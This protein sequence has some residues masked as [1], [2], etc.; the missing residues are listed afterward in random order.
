V[1]TLVVSLGSLPVTPGSISG[2]PV[3][4]SGSSNTYEIAAVGGATSYAWTLPVGWLGSSTTDTIHTLAGTAGGTISVTASNGCG[5]SSAQILNV[6]VNLSPTP[7]ISL[8]TNNICF[9]NAEGIIKATGNP[10][11]GT[12]SGTGVSPS[13][14][15][16]PAAAGV[17]VHTITYV[18]TDGNGCSGTATDQVTVS[19]CVSTT[20]L[21][22]QTSN[23]FVYPNPT[24]GLVTL[25]ISTPLNAGFVE[26]CGQC[27]LIIYSVLGDVILQ[28]AINNPTTTLDLSEATPGIYFLQIKN[29]NSSIIKKIIK[30]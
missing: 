20:N 28:S 12:F 30:Q 11:G 23:I 14:A 7:T 29:E 16:D 21:V 5:T 4:C 22:S 6:N 17:G 9:E 15:F 27:S 10:T 25:S 8:T 1:Q 26:G 18:F 3:V 13:G 2:K 19:T 24:N